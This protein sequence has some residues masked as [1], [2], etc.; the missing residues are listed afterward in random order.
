MADLPTLSARLPVNSLHAVL[1]TGL[2]IAAALNGFGVEYRSI[3]FQSR[4][5][6]PLVAKFPF[7]VV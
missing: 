3:Q 6:G 2:L 5:A 4:D 7:D 1:A